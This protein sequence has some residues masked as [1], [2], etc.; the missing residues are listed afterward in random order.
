M[1]VLAVWGWLGSAPLT[2]AEVLGSGGMAAAASVVPAAVSLE[3]AIGAALEGSVSGARTALKD[4]RL[5]KLTLGEADENSAARSLA[6][7]LAVAGSG[8][9]RATLEG[10]RSAF[11]PTSSLSFGYTESNG[12]SRNQFI[13]RERVVESEGAK[14]EGSVV[15]CIFVDGEIANT[16][17]D[18]CVD[19]LELAGEEEAASSD[20]RLRSWFGSVS[21]AKGFAWGGSLS[22][23]FGST[24]KIKTSYDVEGLQ[25]ILSV[26]DPFGF[27]SRAPWT[28]SLSFSFSSPLP[29]TKGFGAQGNSAGV[30]LAVAEATL[31]RSRWERHLARLTAQQTTRLGYWD[32]VGAVERLK[33]TRNLAAAVWDLEGRMRRRYSR[34]YLT[35]YEFKQI[36]AEGKA[37]A[38]QEESAWSGFV[39]ASHAL[40]ASL[41][42][43]K[44][45]PAPLLLPIDYQAELR[46]AAG[47]PT[48]DAVAR[49]LRR[50]PELKISSEDSGTARLQERFRRYQTR[51]DLSFSLSYNLAQTDSA[52][53]YD[54]WRASA[55]HIFG[56][57]SDEIF[58]GLTYTVPL[59]NGAVKAAHRRALAARKG[60]EA[61]ERQAVSDVVRQVNA[62]TSQLR[63]AEFRIKDAASRLELAERA[64]NHAVRMLE[65]ER[66]SS[67]ELINRYRAVLAARREDVAARV[68]L[69]QVEARLV[70]L[71]GGIEEDWS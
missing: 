40:A 38:L 20:S 56:P 47:L 14:T 36:V 1:S 11:D 2:A 22:A 29:L 54:T 3:A 71:M 30:G 10:S 46:A 63:Q 48:E 12:H 19:R 68:A 31:R 24:Y 50:F 61:V 34:G 23:T 37:L 25:S 62:A 69:R 33:L 35:G 8:E 44:Q 58:V 16:D 39:A 28:S 17:F 27:S 9:R 4:L 21:L 13:I 41:D 43:L 59:W 57:D 32:L 65:L 67:F 26:Q 55:V 5:R 15:G 70:R 49:A 64:L 7:A 18:T 52:F 66:I 42:W 51:P 45:E 53:G 60:A 6:V